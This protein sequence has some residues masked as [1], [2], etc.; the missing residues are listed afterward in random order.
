MSQEEIE[1]LREEE[2]EQAELIYDE[3]YCNIIEE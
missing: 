1:Q 3:R 2:V